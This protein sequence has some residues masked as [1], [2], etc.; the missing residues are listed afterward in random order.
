MPTIPKLSSWAKEGAFVFVHSGSE[1]HS[2]S[3]RG[4][5][6]VIHSIESNGCLVRL[7]YPTGEIGDYI[8]ESAFTQLD[9]TTW[10]GARKV[11]LE[12]VAVPMLD[13]LKHEVSV[14]V[15]T[16]RAEIARLVK[17]PTDEDELAEVI[18]TLV[19]EDKESVV[20]ALTKLKTPHTKEIWEVVDAIETKLRAADSV[21]AGGACNLDA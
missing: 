12:M 15:V 9:A 7:K 1:H 21:V 8:A 14:R 20:A 17:Y 6:M 4:G 5:P 16:I 3:E 13:E 11:F 2:Y 18:Q 10:R 19:S